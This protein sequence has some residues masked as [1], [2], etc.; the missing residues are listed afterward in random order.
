MRRITQIASE[1][2]RVHWQA[3]SHRQQA[4]GIM[5]L[6]NPGIHRQ[7]H[8]KTRLVNRTSQ[9][10]VWP[11]FYLTSTALYVIQN[12]HLYKNTQ[13]SSQSLPRTKQWALK[14]LLNVT[15]TNI[16]STVL[17]CSAMWFEL[18]LAIYFQCINTFSTFKCVSPPCATDRDSNHI[19][20]E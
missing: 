17:R 19:A 10:P 1:T 8:H 2:R 13:T 16:T 6:Q 14:E 18:S 20:G 11:L 7:V 4:A 5:C 3:L 15:P 12:Y 9:W